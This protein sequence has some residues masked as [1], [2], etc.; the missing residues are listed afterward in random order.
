MTV[1]KE[2]TITNPQIWHGL[3]AGYDGAYSFT[4]LLNTA[5]LLEVY[6]VLRNA[7]DKQS[8]N[9]AASFRL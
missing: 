4:R 8:S 7:I 9:I 1:E 6:K 3:Q 5:E 2:E